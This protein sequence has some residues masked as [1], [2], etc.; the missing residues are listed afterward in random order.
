MGCESSTK[1]VGFM[2]KR[3]QH[4]ETD[5][6]QK[7]NQHSTFK[8]CQN[9]RSVHGTK[10]IILPSSSQSMQNKSKMTLSS[11]SNHDIPPPPSSTSSCDRRL[12][13][14][15]RSILI[16]KTLPILKHYYYYY[17]K[18]DYDKQS[19]HY[20]N[21]KQKT[22]EYYQ[23]TLLSLM[24]NPNKCLLN[25]KRDLY[26]EE[27][28]LYQSIPYRNRR[29][30]SSQRRDNSMLHQC[31]ICGKKFR[32]MFYLDLHYETK[33]QQSNNNT[34]IPKNSDMFICPAIELCN[35]LGGIS[36]CMEKSL[37]DEPYYA[38]G[39]H[40]SIHP[41]LY[42]KSIQRTYQK[43]V[44]TQPCS[45]TNI[46]IQIQ[47]C[48]EMIDTCFQGHDLLIHDMNSLLCDTQSCHYKLHS[49]LNSVL[50]IHHGREY[51]DNHHDDINSIGYLGLFFIGVAILYYVWVSN[52]LNI[53]DK[54]RRWRRW[55]KR[56]ISIDDVKK[57][58]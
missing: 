44:H 5:T 29:S 31:Y 52:L 22:M 23:K 6:R 42:S 8:Q 53:V 37:E 27:E 1:G 4:H 58:D 20:Q 49:I 9:T 17:Q 57:F 28:R 32:S 15:V 54:M 21:D 55:D 24:T 45:D 33:H 26:W 10:P 43:E 47:S 2:N 48:Y 56:K 35:R 34:S 50:S 36:T 25:P 46:H 39:I 11:S 18:D 19:Y 38:P 40:N 7:Q 41:N 51:W 3:R 14:A 12:S 16:D 13:R 30:S